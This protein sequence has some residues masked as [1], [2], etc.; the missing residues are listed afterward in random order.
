M[1]GIIMRLLTALEVIRRLTRQIQRR[2]IPQ[3][4]IKLME[5]E[6]KLT[7]PHTPGPQMRQEPTKEIFQAATQLR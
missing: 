6:N 4:Q 3:P 2:Q 1:M 5:P 7:T